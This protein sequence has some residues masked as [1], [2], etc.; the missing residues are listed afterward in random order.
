[1][2]DECSSRAVSGI[3]GGLRRWRIG[4]GLVAGVAGCLMVVGAGEPATGVPDLGSRMDAFIRA[5]AEFVRECRVTER[6]VEQILGMRQAL[7]SLN[8]KAEAW[9]ETAFETGKF[10]YDL[11]VND[12]VYRA[13]AAE[14]GVAPREFLQ[15]IIRLQLF[16]ASEEAAEGANASRA[17]LNAQL[18]EL[19]EMRSQL[20]GEDY[21]Q[22]KSMLESG[23]ATLAATQK[24]FVGLPVLEESEQKLLAK[25]RDR[26]REALQAGGE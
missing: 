3:L 15:K 23:A 18:K 8:A 21:R 22:M 13:W 14:H 26:L 24:A 7:E 19:E 9:G 6:D 25:Y 12:A 5:S 10:D 2:F 17:R 4:A 20:S 11:L 16:F 1:M